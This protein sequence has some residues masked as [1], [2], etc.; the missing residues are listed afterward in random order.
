[1][2]HENEDLAVIER[3][4]QRE[5]NLDVEEQ[6]RLEAMVDKEVIEVMHAQKH[7]ATNLYYRFEVM[8]GLNSLQVRNKIEW[9][10]LAKCYLHDV[11]KRECWDSMKF[12]GRA[13]KVSP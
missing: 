12:R 10:I 6:G 7:N 3:L 8:M 5:F 4:E 2:M 9:E 13:I 1:M 11:L